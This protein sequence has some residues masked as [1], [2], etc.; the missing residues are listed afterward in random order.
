[1]TSSSCLVHRK[2]VAFHLQVL[3]LADGTINDADTH[4]PYR[5]LHF[6]DIRPP[7]LSGAILRVDIAVILMDFS[8]DFFIIKQL[9]S[10]FSGCITTLR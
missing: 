2:L 3:H 10:L 9:I 6:H 4:L 8:T 7:L 1:M 5:I